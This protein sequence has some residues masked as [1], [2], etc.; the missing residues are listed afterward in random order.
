MLSGKAGFG[1]PFLR[2]PF[3]QPGAAQRGTSRRRGRSFRC[4]TSTTGRIGSRFRPSG[5]SRSEAGNGSRDADPMAG[6]G[7]RMDASPA[8]GPTPAC[9]NGPCT[10]PS[11]RRT[12]II[13]NL[14]AGAI[15]G[16]FD[17]QASLARAMQVV[18]AALHRGRSGGRHRVERGQR[19][20]GRWTSRRPA[21]TPDDGGGPRRWLIPGSASRQGRIRRRAAA[22]GR[23]TGGKGRRRSPPTGRTAPCPARS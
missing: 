5:C 14:L 21:P 4:C 17:S 11:P 10:G 12:P 13:A 16:S 8:S 1:P 20:P 6:T 7:R 15:P 23:R 3:E 9:A 22:S 18:D 19:E 2:S